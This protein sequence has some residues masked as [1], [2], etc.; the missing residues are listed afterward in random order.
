M[1]FLLAYLSC[2]PCWTPPLVPEESVHQLEDIYP[3]TSPVGP[4]G[5]L[6]LV[7]EEP[8]HQLEELIV[9][10]RSGL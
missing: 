9:L 2:R 3:V 6:P 5:L 8:V 1:K 10:L 4:A 7:P